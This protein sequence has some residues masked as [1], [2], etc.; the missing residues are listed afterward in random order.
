MEGQFE[1]PT[2]EI[3]RLRRSISDLVSILSL[4]ALW[5]GG[6]AS[7]VVSTLLD[8]L[9]GMLDLDF[10]YIRLNASFDEMP[11]EM[12]RS[13]TSFNVMGEPGEFLD[14]SFGYDAENWP[15]SAKL[16]LGDS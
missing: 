1:D 7:Q 10:V 5:A 14:A 3:N 8:A 6:E 2:E 4:P 13:A 16:R 15:P 11:L 12:V 9:L